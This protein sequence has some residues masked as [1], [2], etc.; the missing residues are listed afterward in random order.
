[1]GLRAG[2]DWCG[3]SRP[4]RIRY[5]DRP[6]RRQSIYR[7]H[8][9]AH[10]LQINNHINWKNCIEE[11]IPKLTGACYAAKSMVHISNINSVTSVYSTYF[12]SIITHGLFWVTLPTVG[13]FSHY[14][15]KLSE[16]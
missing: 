5:P 16:L 11:M 13:K 2:L 8:Y 7:L 1:M 6:A 3:K 9:P 4:T 12:H 14:K 10:G 15:R